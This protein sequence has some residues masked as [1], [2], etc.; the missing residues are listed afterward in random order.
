M[1]KKIIC[2]LA[3]GMM[4][5]C[6]CQEEKE[7]S[8]VKISLGEDFYMLSQDTLGRTVDLKQSIEGLNYQNL[9]LLRSYVYATHGHWFME[10]DLNTFFRQHAQ[11]YEELCY[12]EIEE[13]PYEEGIAPEEIKR[14]KE[15]AQALWENYPHAY[16]LVNLT[17]EEQAF[18]AK[19]DKRMAELME[20]KEYAGEDE[21]L[22][23]NPNL[24]V[25]WFQ[26]S[27]HDEEMQERLLKSNVAIDS[28]Q[29]EQLFQIY[30]EN[31]K[32]MMPSFI[33]TDL[34]LQ[35]YQ[36]FY[37]YMITTTER[38]GFKQQVDDVDGTILNCLYD[39]T[40]NAKRP[41]PMGLDVFAAF[42]V[43]AARQLLDTCYHAQELWDGYQPKMDSLK[44]QL[45]NYDKWDD[46]FSN[47]WMENLLVLQ[48]QNRNMPGFMQ[49]STWEL[50]NLHT[51]LASWALMKHEVI[52][53][54]E[55][56]RAADEED[57]MRGLPI[58][59]Q[60]GYV[61]PNVPFW[62]KL[63]ETIYHHQQMLNRNGLM[64]D[65][66]TEK[67][68]LLKS[69]INFCLRVS[70]SEINGEVL[71]S[72]DMERIKHFGKEIE[73]FTLTVI[74]PDKTLYDWS[75]VKG[76]K[77]MVAQVSEVMTRNVKGCEKNGR[78][79]EA[80]GNPNEIFVVVEINGQCYL[81]RGA[82]YS[83]HEMVRN[84]NQPRLTDKEWQEMLKSS[85][86]KQSKM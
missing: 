21:A 6:A 58:P 53:T 37:T 41:Y 17:A 15:Y 34:L 68:E 76:T 84:L 47:K 50:K 75:E 65:D 79:Y 66:L 26:I 74:D 78:L 4:M 60:V 43:K 57:R 9:R 35:A 38:Q 48:K 54:T 23:L 28:T 80:T 70:E 36:S 86:D 39:Q 31:D 10:G 13:K 30:E 85:G 82:T 29:H 27:K 11:W 49:T 20:N 52:G 7:Q 71:N 40:P 51:A 64:N 72:D 18:V 45:R 61:E 46:S 81:S 59:Y 1:T 3:V 67:S 63:K 24:A 22:L 69:Y 25:N 73:N 55:K 16:E 62:K 32:L 77:R 14:I 56:R 12:V 33:T 2:G 42:G 19:I 83:Y 8:P 44:Q 5:L